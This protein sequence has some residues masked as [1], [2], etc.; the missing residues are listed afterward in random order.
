MRVTRER[1]G[2]DRGISVEEVFFEGTQERVEEIWTDRRMLIWLKE[3][4]GVL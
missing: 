2:I 4:T 1:Y 3:R